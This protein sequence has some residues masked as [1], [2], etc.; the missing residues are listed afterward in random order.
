MNSA[1]L[2]TSFPRR[3]DVG[4]PHPHERR[5]QIFKQIR[6]WANILLV[7]GAA[8]ILA[9]T[10]LTLVSLH[11]LKTVSRTAEESELRHYAAMA[12][13]Q[14][15]EEVGLAE[16]LSVLVAEMPEVQARFAAGDRDWLPEQL[17]PPFVALE[18]D[19]GAVQFQFHTAPA[20]SFLRLHMLESFGDDLSSFRQSVVDTNR[21]IKPHRGLQ[22]GVGGLGARGVVPVLREGRHLGSVEFGMSFGQT[23]FDDFKA[24]YGVEAALDI[25]RND[26][27][28]T[29]ASTHEGQ[30]FL[31]SDALEAA[32]AGEFQVAELRIGTKPVAASAITKRIRRLANEIDRVTNG[33]LSGGG[34]AIDG[35][36]ELA[37]LA[38]TLDGM[39]GHLNALVTGVET[40]AFS[41]HAASRE[42]AQGI[43]QGI[44]DSASAADILQALVEA[45]SETSTSAQQISLSTQQQRTA[46]DQV[47]AALRE[48]VTASSETAGAVRQIADIARDMRELSSA[49]Q[50]SLDQFVLNG[51]Q[52]PSADPGIA[53]RP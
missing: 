47:V 14:I 26:E 27:L 42:I 12:Q 20:M 3:T 46:S 53:S 44:A 24:S 21:D 40:T 30:P 43:A 6:L 31:G 45:A 22:F 34:G 33:D 9:I 29:F 35:N 49:L 15:R 10:T 28:Q 5:V 17:R 50:G 1:T 4:R 38:R 16:A 2:A 7:I 39:R 41:V 37:D 18:R 51:A 23:F 19:F 25:L 36:D 52:T 13:M 32:F 11:N 8:I 48:I